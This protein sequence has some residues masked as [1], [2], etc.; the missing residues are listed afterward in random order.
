[1]LFEWV[2]L[3]FE[4]SNDLIKQEAQQLA[5]NIMQSQH[6]TYEDCVLEILGLSDQ[7]S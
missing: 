1:M 6:K 3:G 2:K 5:A 4:S 7:I